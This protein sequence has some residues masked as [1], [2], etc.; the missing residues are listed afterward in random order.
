MDI[1]QGSTSHTLLTRPGRCWHGN[2]LLLTAPPVQFG[3]G[4]SGTDL[5]GGRTGRGGGGGG[6]SGGS[7]CGGYWRAGWRSGRAA[8][9][10]G[11]WNKIR[12]CNINIIKTPWLVVMK[13][14]GNDF[15]R[16]NCNPK[17]LFLSL[18]IIV[19]GGSCQ[20]AKRQ[21][22]FIFISFLHTK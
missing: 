19:G 9:C 11:D 4:Q 22:Y 7:H 15:Q 17:L 10:L 13:H 12:T 20:L 8:L 5:G 14:A 2:D 16:P 3:T 21:G 6:G 18:V 1:R